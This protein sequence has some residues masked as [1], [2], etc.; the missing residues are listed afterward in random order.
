MYNLFLDDF[1][2][3]MMAY[4]HTK[5]QMFLN[6]KW[7][8]V[9]NYEE[10]CD[11]INKNGVPKFVSFDHDLADEHY[12][13][14]MTNQEYSEK[15]GYDCAKFLINYCEKHNIDF[16]NYY[17]H[18]ANP[19]GAKRIYNIIHDALYKKPNRKQE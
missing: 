17:V 1:R 19:I 2:T 6:Y 16:P 9:K 10:F 15:T 12:V 18:S 14:N 11:Y 5:E 4:A 3:P 7:E 13:Q 8:I